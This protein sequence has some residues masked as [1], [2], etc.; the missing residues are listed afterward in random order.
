MI[1]ND[2]SKGPIPIVDGGRG[3]GHPDVEHRKLY[4]C[5]Q[6]GQHQRAPC[7]DYRPDEDAARP[8]SGPE[9]VGPIISSLNAVVAKPMLTTVGRDQGPHTKAVEQ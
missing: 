9:D 8:V 5:G 3:R 1:K 2:L 6:S 4:D 7:T